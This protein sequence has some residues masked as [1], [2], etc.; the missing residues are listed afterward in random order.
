[1]KNIYILLI[2]FISI[3]NQTNPLFAQSGC[4]N[5]D[6]SLGIEGGGWTGSTG[7]NK[8]GTYINPVTGLK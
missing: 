5:A 6:F 4:V 2:F 3:F 8:A 1:M 7:E